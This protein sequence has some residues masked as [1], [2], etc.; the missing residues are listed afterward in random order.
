MMNSESSVSRVLWL[1]TPASSLALPKV[2]I[3]WL[4]SLLASYRHES[5]VHVKLVATL[6]GFDP[7]SAVGTRACGFIWHLCADCKVQLLS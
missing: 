7:L 1:L 3:N 5:L 4:I 2:L 6:V